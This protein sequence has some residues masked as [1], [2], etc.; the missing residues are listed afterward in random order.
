V[1]VRTP[2]LLPLVAAS[3]TAAPSLAA[4]DLLPD[5]ITVEEELLDHDVSWGVAA[6][7]AR[8]RLRNGTAN[9]GDGPLFL[10]GVFP[11]HPDGTQDV[12]QRI[13]RDDQTFYDRF[14]GTFVYHET[15][16]HVHF[17]DW[18]IYRLR[19]LLPGGGVGGVVM[20]GEKTSFCL[21]DSKAYDLGLP[22]APPTAQYTE[23]ESSQG[24]SVGW[25]D[26]YAKTLPGQSL[27]ACG[28]PSGTYWLESEADPE[29]SVLELDET[30]NVARVQVTIPPPPRCNDG[31]DNDGDFAVDFPADPGCSG[32]QSD[33]ENPACNDGLDNDNDG[34]VD[35]P[36]DSGCA[37]AWDGIEGAPACGIGF[38]L[39]F[40]LLL[41]KPRSRTTH[42]SQHLGR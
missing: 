39:A 22:G 21:L 37:S 30:N 28:I 20:E 31:A 24:I 23:C 27:L 15:H 40:V 34:R 18:A 11:V 12:M 2:W 8:I 42:R 26:I 38:E 41:L 10:V 29:D 9:V 19:E 3:L 1:Q 16:L 36:A 35:Y 7:C 4:T 5:V 25:T 32:L 13:Y 33:I 6:G 17:E 14:A